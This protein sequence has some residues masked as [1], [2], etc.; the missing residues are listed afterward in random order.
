MSARQNNHGPAYTPD[1]MCLIVVAHRASARYPL[2]IAANRDE[3]YARPSL[4]AAFWEDGQV[5]GGRDEVHGGSW[6][7]MTRTGRFAAVTNLRG[8]IRS[9]QARSRGSLVTNFVRGDDDPR[10]YAAAVAADRHHYAGFHLLI[11]RLGGDLVQLSGA[12]TVL[13]PGIHGLSNAPVDVR[14]RK[15]DLATD[16]VRGALESPNAEAV[17]EELLR[18]LRTAPAKGDVTRNLFIEGTQY[19]TRAST[20]IVSDGGNV[21]FVEQGYGPR[22]VLLGARNS[23]SFALDGSR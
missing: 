23:S 18:I 7:A 1:A 14:W 8:A 21:L 9:P 2:R 11:G 15:V 4:A 5:I 3:E 6:L 13:E 17:V 16:A 20:V 22:G 12:P 19:G 10:T